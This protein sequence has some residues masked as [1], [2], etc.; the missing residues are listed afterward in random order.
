MI[1]YSYYVLDIIHQGH[2]LMMKNSKRIAGENG[3][4]MVGVLTDEATMEK[5][6]RP[7]IAF[8]ER[9]GIAQAIKYI[10]IVVPQENYSPIQNIKLIKPDI[11]MESSSHN[12]NDISKIKSIVEDYGGKVITMPYFPYQSSTNIKQKI[13][14]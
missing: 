3:L 10:D 12:I 8:I 2:I 1:V 5:K 14:E 9:F 13:R 4:S 11:V 7:A 6:P